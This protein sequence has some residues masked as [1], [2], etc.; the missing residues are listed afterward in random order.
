MLKQNVTS[1]IMRHLYFHILT[2]NSSPLLP[3]VDKMMCPVCSHWSKSQLLMQKYDYTDAVQYECCYYVFKQFNQ[4]SGQK[5]G[6]NYCLREHSEQLRSNMT[7]VDAGYGQE[8]TLVERVR[9]CASCVC[10]TYTGGVAVH[11]ILSITL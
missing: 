10:V 11:R 6:H 4:Q 2:L 7:L 3:V 9:A 1:T 8:W 5:K